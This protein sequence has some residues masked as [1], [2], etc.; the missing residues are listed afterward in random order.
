MAL[1]WS[2]YLITFAIGLGGGLISGMVTTLI[3]RMRLKRR[4]KRELK[5]ITHVKKGIKCKTCDKTIH[6][7]S[8]FCIYCGTPVVGS[9]EC[10]KCQIPLPEDALH[11]YLCDGNAKY[12]GGK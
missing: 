6:K 3:S 5:E 8:V 10:D 12:I 2:S 11:C 1:D 7:E 4:L 9:K